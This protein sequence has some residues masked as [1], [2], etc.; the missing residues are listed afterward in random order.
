MQKSL[1]DIAKKCEI[2][3]KNLAERSS[4]K[5]TR[6]SEGPAE[7]PPKRA[8]PTNGPPVLNTTLDRDTAKT[9]LFEVMNDVSDLS[10]IYSLT[11]SPSP[12]TDKSPTTPSKRA[13]IW[14]RPRP[15]QRK[16]KGRQR[17]ER[18][19]QGTK[20]LARP[21][22]PQRLELRK[23]DHTKKRRKHN[24][25]KTEL[26]SNGPLALLFFSR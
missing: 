4:R 15:S 1:N 10:N 7:A 20:K 13:K 16:G 6:E 12:P 26:M 8:R 14:P 17:R 24:R 19:N 3:A 18:R 23:K 21:P 2:E 25:L 22:K 5:R 11:Y 9:S